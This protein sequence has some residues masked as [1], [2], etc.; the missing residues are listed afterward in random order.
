MRIGNSSSPNMTAVSH[1]FIDS[2]MVHAGGEFVK[3]Y[4][5]LLRLSESGDVS[6]SELADRLAQTETDVKRALRYWEKEGLLVLSGEDGEIT[7]VTL[8]DPEKKQ[9]PLAEP[10]E[11]G[12]PPAREKET[13]SR[14]SYSALQL[15]QLQKHQDFAQLL[16]AVERYLGRPLTSWDTDMYAYLYEELGFPGEVLE[17]LT[18][19]CVELWERE[20]KKKDFHLIRYMEKVALNWH[21]EGALTLA[22]ARQQTALFVRDSRLYAEIGKALGLKGRQLTES[23]TRQISVWTRDMEM[24]PELIL[25][26]C[27]QTIAAI[28]VPNFKYIDKILINWRQRGFRTINEIRAYEALRSADENKKPLPPAEDAEK[29]ENGAE[30]KDSPRGET[31]IDYNDILSR[32]DAK[33]RVTEDSHYAVDQRAN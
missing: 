12:Q 16:I 18:E 3:T 1:I 5:L 28:N 2:Y 19:Y 8:T 13:D 31:P 30:G 23:E 7:A 21:R 33:R 9:A 22:A 15:S 17:Y 11:N 20:E 29:R 4:L 10:G 6:L 24:S 26:A 27:R 32:L 25:E 14:R